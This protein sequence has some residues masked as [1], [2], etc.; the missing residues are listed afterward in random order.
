MSALTLEELDKRLEAHA[1]YILG[2]AKRGFDEMS[3][4][5]QA[6]QVTVGTLGKDLLIVKETL[7]AQERKLLVMEQKFETFT[8]SVDRFVK[9]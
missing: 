1:E 3:E 8:T 4:N 5:F 6:V 2:S 7:V 9:I